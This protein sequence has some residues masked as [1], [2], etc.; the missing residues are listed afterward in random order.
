[1]RNYLKIGDK[2]LLKN[3]KEVTVK[4]CCYNHISTQELN[5]FVEKKDIVKI[6]NCT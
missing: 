6:L 4:S 3:G 1:M 2:V 5:V